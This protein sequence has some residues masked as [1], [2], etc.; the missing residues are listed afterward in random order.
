MSQ[1]NNCNLGRRELNRGKNINIKTNKLTAINIILDKIET[2]SNRR[3]FA[4]HKSNRQ[5]ENIL[6][7]APTQDESVSD[8]C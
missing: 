8:V 1:N 2:Q 7:F 4:Q 3:K 6:E 5:T